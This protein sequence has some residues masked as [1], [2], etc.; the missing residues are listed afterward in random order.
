MASQAD[1]QF[2]AHLLRRTSFYVSR[3]QVES[4]AETAASDRDALIAQLVDNARAPRVAA[5]PGLRNTLG[6]GQYQ[7]FRRL[8]KA[9]IKRL[10]SPQ[11]GLGDRLLWFWHG[12][13]TTAMSK[14]N[15]PGLLW[16]QHRLLAK[17]ALGNYRQ[18]LID[19]TLD[20]AMLLYLDGAGSRA[21]GDSVPNENYARELM[22]LF[23]LGR[24]DA[25]GNPNYSQGDVTAGAAALAGWSI[26]R[27]P[28]KG[29]YNP[30]RVAAAFD[31]EAAFSGTTL[32]LGKSFNFDSSIGGAD[33]VAAVV[34]QIL[35]QPAAALN[36]VRKLFVYFVHSSP[37]EDTLASLAKTFR[38]NSFEI[39]PVLKQ[40]FRLPEFSAT[41]ALQG[42]ARLPLE[43]LLALLSATEFP[44]KAIRHED[45]FY[46]AGQLPF[47]PPSV[48]GW[49]VGNRWLLVTQSMARAQVAA[50]AFKVPKRTRLLK[51]LARANDPATDL[52]KTLNLHD[53]SEPTR[54]QVAAML[55]N[56][57]AKAFDSILGPVRAALA[58]GLTSPEFALT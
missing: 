4:L 49:T 48:A 15:L 58:L 1:Y 55:D 3:Q 10:S 34:D 7:D 6:K 38:D 11:S 44:A 2:A 37:S 16:R 53:V 18:M 17:H 57:D 27:L 32:L 51:S 47:D 23:S 42:R 31:G 30:Y 33:R 14:V 28:G 24:V 8:L 29:R 20:P 45:Y 50:A 13:L 36:I 46:A 41:E 19:L 21:D 40:L 22:E 52:L 5:N 25:Q 43:W 54:A 9:E 39:L 26:R 35:A 56:A 12:F